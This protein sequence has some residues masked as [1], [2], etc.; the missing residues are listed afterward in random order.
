MRR[1]S[2]LLKITALL[3]T[4]VVISEMQAAYNVVDRFKLV[5]D[6]LYTHEMLN[7]FGHDFIFDV[8]AYLNKDV[9]D[10]IDEAEKLS[11][12]SGTVT[13][14]IA[15]ADAFM[16]KYNKTEQNVRIKLNLG[17]PLPT[18]HVKGVKIVPD[19]RIG[20]GV[21]VML[22]FQSEVFDLSAVLE[23]LPQ[24]FPQAGKDAA[25]TCAAADL[26]P[27][28]DIVQEMVNA[29]CIP[30]N[31]VTSYI[32]KYFVPASGSP[33]LNG[34]AKADF[35]AGLLFNYF[36][37]ENWFGHV[38][39]YGHGKLDVKAKVSG[40]SLAQNTDDVVDFGDEMNTTINLASDLQ[41]GYK[42]GN[43]SASVGIEEIKLSRMADNE[44]KGVK[45]NYGDDPLIR[46]HGKYRYEFLA[47][48]VEPFGGLHKRSGYGIS[49]GIYGGADVGAFFW[50]DRLGVRVR[51]MADKEHITF[52]PMAKL[53]FAS[54]EYMLKSPMSS[55][56]DG[57]KPA[58][59][60]SLNF[61]LFF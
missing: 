54:L 30:A 53:W 10:V 16:L 20:A 44:D 57:V 26:S 22:G 8:G 25:A 43:L 3:C 24:D 19:L 61:R 47:F 48:H 41:F 6:K 46:L 14:K 4:V 11:K 52:S 35:R 51:A 59:I 50:G 38:K 42:N 9:Q 12:G 1:M 37:Q 32:G 18:F 39:F 58:T 49:D 36:Y 2:T 21:G 17:V 15:D 60:H 55:E 7:P 29:G 45:L 34:F 5:E 40:N 31:L 27:G 28:N 33:V 23:Y 13:E 56:V